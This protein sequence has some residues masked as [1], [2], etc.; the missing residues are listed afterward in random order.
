MSRQ[1]EIQELIEELRQSLDELYSENIFLTNFV[2]E[3]GLTEEYESYRSEVETRYL[4]ESFSKEALQH[5]Q[6]DQEPLTGSKPNR[7]RADRRPVQVRLP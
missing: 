3:Q 1:E 2:S 4:Q 5:E 7:G 6:M